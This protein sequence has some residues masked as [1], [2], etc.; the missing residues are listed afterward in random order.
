MQ[1]YTNDD[2]VFPILKL[3]ILGIFILSPLMHMCA[4]SFDTL[5][6]NNKDLKKN[7]MKMKHENYMT[8][9]ITK[10]K[11]KTLHGKP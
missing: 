6:N 1:A 9:Y 5:I 7:V 2:N 11:V 10:G 3:H 8:S 4:L